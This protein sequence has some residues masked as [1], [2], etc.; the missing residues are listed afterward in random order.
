MASFIQLVVTHDR[1]NS[2]EIAEETDE[3]GLSI[4]SLATLQ[5][6]DIIIP[7]WPLNHK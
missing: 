6:A 7:G 3:N 2:Q 4:L 1:Q 5:G